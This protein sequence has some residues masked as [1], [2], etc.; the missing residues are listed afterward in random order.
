MHNLLTV[1]LVGYPENAQK[2]FWFG[3][4]GS[5]GC[6]LLAHCVVEK[7]GIYQLD[8][9][10]RLIGRESAPPMLLIRKLP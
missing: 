5:S 7:V 2:T 6:T 10:R 8:R 3:L 9:D 1:W 4:I